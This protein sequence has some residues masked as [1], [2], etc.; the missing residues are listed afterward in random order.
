MDLARPEPPS[1][2][3]FVVGSNAEPIAALADLGAGTS[4]E[5]GILLWGAPGAGKSHLLRATAARAAATRPI[6]ECSTPA[7]ITSA[8]VSDTALVIVDSIDGADTL[9]QGRL[10][11][12]LN[13]L[14]S[15]GG[16]WLAAAS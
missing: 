16:Q 5:N 2:D 4:R 7:E 14:P 1:F 11:T 13:E 15:R 6:V 10:F 12:L 3:N 8:S 9:A